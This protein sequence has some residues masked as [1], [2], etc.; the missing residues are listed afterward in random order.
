MGCNCKRVKKTHDLLSND[1]DD[2]L[3]LGNR[4]VISIITFIV[5]IIFVPIVFLYLMFFV[6]TGRS[7]RIT[8]PKFILNKF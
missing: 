3:G 7:N 8:L 5:S 2:K 1:S 6:L 4:I